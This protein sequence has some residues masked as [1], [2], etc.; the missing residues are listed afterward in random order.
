MSSYVFPRAVLYSFIWTVS[1]VELGLT[2][3]RVHHTKSTAG[4][5]DP[6]VVEL[7]VTAALTLIWLPASV[8]MHLM[9]ARELGAAGNT[10]YA[11]LHGETGG[12]FIL[13]VLWIVGAA[14]STH[15]WPNSALA[16]T[17]KSGHILLSIVAFA[18]L[19]FIALT[20]AK[21][22]TAMQYAALSAVSTTPASASTPAAHEK[23]AETAAPAS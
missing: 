9:K 5:Y 3:Y 14:F 8:F 23:P 15:K 13:W 12:N 2:G 10:G 6:I 20:L 11:P 1:V 4:F 17:G 18:W 16:G 21:I 19:A 22:F 7:I